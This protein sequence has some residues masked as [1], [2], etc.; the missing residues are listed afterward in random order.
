MADELDDEER[1]ILEKH[2]KEKA[3]KNAAAESELFVEIWDEGGRGA[4]VPYAKGKSWLQ[5]TFGIDADDLKPE[6]DAPAD[7]EPAAKVRPAHFGGRRAA[8]G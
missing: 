2:R 1:A 5:K 8:G 3:A 4:R 6:E 7:D